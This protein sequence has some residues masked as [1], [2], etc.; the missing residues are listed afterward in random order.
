[1]PGKDVR[2]R[3]AI[4]RYINSWGEDIEVLKEK[5]VGYRFVGTPR[6][7][8]IVLRHGSRYMGI[9]AKLQES[10]GTA[11]QKLSYTLEDCLACPIPTI[12]VF[13]GSGIKE[14]MKSKLILSGRGIEVGFSPDEQNP[15][16][17]RIN[18]PDMI[19]R[20]RVYIELGLDWFKLFR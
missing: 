3:D 20:Q 12:I 15:E 4:I 8:D 16:K 7:L 17:D 5:P 10:S 9:E 19:L 1:M 6:V 14:D 11:Y 13:A 18:D 2:F